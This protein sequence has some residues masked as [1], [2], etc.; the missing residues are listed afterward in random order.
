MERDFDARD[1]CRLF[2]VRAY[3]SFRNS[4]FKAYAFSIFVVHWQRLSRG[5]EQKIQESGFVVVAQY[6]VVLYLLSRFLSPI[7]LPVGG[8]SNNPRLFEEDGEIYLL[9]PLM[10]VVLIPTCGGGRFQFSRQ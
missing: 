8:F 2:D 5:G 3:R 7:I 10:I 6:P 9:I 4:N 1:P